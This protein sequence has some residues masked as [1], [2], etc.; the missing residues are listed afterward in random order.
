MLLHAGVGDRR[1]WDGQV[2]AF[3]RERLVVRPDLRGFGESPLPGGPFSHVEDVRALLEHLGLRRADLVG[4]SFGGRVA[5]DFALAHPERTG[6][7]VLVDSALTGWEGSPELDAFDE[8][9]DALL[10][11]GKLDEAV[12]LNVRTWLDGQGRGT[13]PVPDATRTRLAGMQL[14]AFETIVRAYEG[15]PPPGP[16]GWSEPPAATR[17]AEVTARTLVLVGAYDLADFRAIGERLGS[18]IPGAERA[19]LE[20]AHL[21]ALERPDEFNRLVLDFLR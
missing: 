3:A 14:L 5:L 20:T 7:L 2:E 18:E 10:E 13:A 17:L 19:V 15:S 1:L 11:D 6:A 4:N 8:D 12:D 16:V 21:P 9:E